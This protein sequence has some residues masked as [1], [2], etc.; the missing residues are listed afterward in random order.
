MELFSIIRIPSLA[1][2]REDIPALLAYIA[3]KPVRF[4]ERVLRCLLA[5]SYPYNVRDLFGIVGRAR[6]RTNN[7]GPVL[8]IERE[9]LEENVQNAFAEL[10]ESLR[11]SSSEGQHFFQFEVPFFS[12]ESAKLEFLFE[13]AALILTSI[14]LSNG[15]VIERP[16]SKDYEGSKDDEGIW[17][18][19]KIEKG[20]LTKEECQ[21]RWFALV[22]RVVQGNQELRDDALDM[23]GQIFLRRIIERKKG[24]PTDPITKFFVASYKPESKVKQKDYAKSLDLSEARFSEI[25]SELRPIRNRVSNS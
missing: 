6:K 21:K 16:P 8:E 13:E 19:G 7:V 9:D 24:S 15:N 1:Q 23:I 18:A 17:P 11:L 12:A 3:K 20:G 25:F 5:G 10:F 2:H 14:K 4:D 22:K